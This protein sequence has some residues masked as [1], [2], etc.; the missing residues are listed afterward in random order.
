MRLTG[1]ERLTTT[2]SPDLALR[3]VVCEKH[4]YAFVRWQSEFFF[5]PET[6]TPG[7]SLDSSGGRK[8]ISHKQP[9][10]H[11]TNSP[12]RTRTAKRIAQDIVTTEIQFP[13]PGTPSPSIIGRPKGLRFLGGQ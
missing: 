4:N 2:L 8:A 7:H 13:P 10:V 3:K 12:L 5:V 11:L 9:L 6:K 1:L